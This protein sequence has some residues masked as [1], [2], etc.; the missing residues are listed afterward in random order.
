MGVE[1]DKTKYQGK[2]KPIQKFRAGVYAVIAAIRLS[3]MEEQWRG[4]KMIGDELQVVRAKQLRTKTKG[5][6]REV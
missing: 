3:D 1:V 6:I 5:V 2:L 4:V